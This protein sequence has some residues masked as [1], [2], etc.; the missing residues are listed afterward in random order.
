LPLAAVQQLVT[1]V[2]SDRFRDLEFH[3]LFEYKQRINNFYD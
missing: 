2:T 3:M 1:K